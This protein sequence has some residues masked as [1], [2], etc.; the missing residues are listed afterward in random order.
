MRLA[1][2]CWRGRG[3]WLACVKGVCKEAELKG[4]KKEGEQ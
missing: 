3:V 2:A 1:L 4:G